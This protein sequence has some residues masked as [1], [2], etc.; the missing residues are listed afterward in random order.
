MQFA[1]MTQSRVSIR[2]TGKEWKAWVA[3]SNRA[4]CERLKL[5]LTTK[6]LSFRS[7]ADCVLTFDVTDAASPDMRDRLAQ[8]AVEA[9]EE[10]WYA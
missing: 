2:F 5:A 10:A 6:G 4:K 8:A 3:P 7:A 9:A 1:S